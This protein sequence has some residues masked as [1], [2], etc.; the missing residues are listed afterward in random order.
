MRHLK[1]PLLLFC[2]LAVLASLV[3]QTPIRLPAAEAETAASARELA[4]PPRAPV[5]EASF[6]SDITFGIVPLSVQFTDTSSPGYGVITAWFWDF[7]DGETSLEQN[8]LHIY[9]MPGVFSVSL[10][11]TDDSLRTST[12]LQEDYIHVYGSSPQISL[13]SGASLAYGTVYTEELSDYQAVLISNSGDADLNI[14]SV[15][16]AGNPPQFRL[17]NPDS[18]LL[19]A[20]GA[21]NAIHLCFAP[22]SNGPVADTLIIVNDSRNEPELRITLSGTGIIVAPKA[23]Q[24]LLITKIGNDIQ[25]NWDPVTQNLRDRPLTPDYYFVYV[26]ESPDGYYSFH[27]L[28]PTAQYQHPYA[29]LASPRIFYRVSAVKLYQG[30]I[31]PAERETWL[32]RNLRPGLGEEEMRRVL[33]EFHAE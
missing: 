7:G 23:P 19:L 21:T 33:R 6:S 15:H 29:G 10:T 24:N 28:T 22:Q 3:S 26:A 32:S 4:T 16:F 14:S 25:L 31:F 9:T 8:P 18:A 27:G 11:V 5:L 1:V 13:L 17:L 30:D 12:M 20:P 2:L